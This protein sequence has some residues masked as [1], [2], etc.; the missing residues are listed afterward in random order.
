MTVQKRSIPPAIKQELYKNDELITV[1]TA[2]RLK[3]LTGFMAIAG[4]LKSL[5]GSMAI[6][7]RLK[8]LAGF[9]ARGTTV[10]SLIRQEKEKQI[11][12]Q[13]PKRA[14]RHAAPDRGLSTAHA[15]RDTLLED[16]GTATFAV[17]LHLLFWHHTLHWLPFAPR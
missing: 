15:K 2:G 16:A 10:A 14:V 9:M 7:G 3:S 11:G 5:T 1:A 13:Q 12:L 4:R 8:S 6:A 17:G